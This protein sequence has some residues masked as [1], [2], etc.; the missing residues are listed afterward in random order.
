[1]FCG[2]GLAP[3]NEIFGGKLLKSRTIKTRNRAG[4]AFRL[5]VGSR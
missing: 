1:M 3:K 4:Q 2:V 5:A